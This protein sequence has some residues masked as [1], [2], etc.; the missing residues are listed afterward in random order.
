MIHIVKT[1]ALT[2][3]YAL[4]SITTRSHGFLISL[5]FMVRQNLQYI[6]VVDSQQ[7]LLRKLQFDDKYINVAVPHVLHG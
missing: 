2:S 6:L 1:F 7:F 4:F 5:S 3:G